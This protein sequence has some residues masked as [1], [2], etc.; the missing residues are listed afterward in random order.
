[1]VK[2]ADV[3]QDILDKWKGLSSGSSSSSSSSSGA[4]KVELSTSSNESTISS[5]SVSGDGCSTL[6]LEQD[7]SDLADSASSLSTATVS[8][9]NDRLYGEQ[10]HSERSATV[11]G[12]E[13]LL[14]D[15]TSTAGKDHAVLGF[16]VSPTRG[17]AAEPLEEIHGKESAAVEGRLE[18]VG[19]GSEE[20]QGGKEGLGLLECDESKEQQEQPGEVGDGF[21]PAFVKDRYLCK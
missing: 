19:A 5:V 3:P 1:M 9:H 15:E 13:T 18:A 8:G 2:A 7:S 11:A 14:A 20:V 12:A 16:R 21:R 4:Y 10:Q 17:S 6:G